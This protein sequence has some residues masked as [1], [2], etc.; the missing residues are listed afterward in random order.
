MG[1]TLY[2]AAQRELREETGIAPLPLEQLAL[3]DAPGRDP[4]GRVISVAFLGLIEGEPPPIHAGDDATD[5]AWYPLSALP[6]LAFDHADI[7]R[8][9]QERLAQKQ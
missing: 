3:F 2:H 6:A 7:L 8:C 5:A 9:A 4:R 1:E